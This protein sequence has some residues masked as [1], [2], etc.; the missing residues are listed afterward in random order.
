MTDRQELAASPLW[1][2]V[3][4]RPLPRLHVLSDLHLES[5][6]YEIAP[7]VDFDILVAAGDIGPLDLAVPWLA[8]V[9]KPVVYVLGNHERYGMDILQAVTKAKK[10]AEAT[11]VRVLERDR[12]VINGVRFLGC[13]LWTDL[14]KLHPDFVDAA[15]RMMRDYSH[16]SC[17]EWLTE[18]SNGKRLAGLCK[19]HGFKPPVRD[20][21]DTRT[22]LHPSVTYLEHQASLKWL[23]AQV[24]KPFAGLTV[25]VTHHAPS[26]ESLRRSG[27]SHVALDRTRWG[28]RDPEP[29][30][31][32]AYASDGLLAGFDSKCIDLWVHGHVHTGMDYLEHRIRVVCNPR[33]LHL[34]PITKAEAE[35][36]RFFGYPVS[37]ADIKRSEDVSA[38]NPFCG[39]AAEFDPKLVVD[40]ERGFERPI[41]QACEEP[42]EKMRELAV[43][44]KELLP[45]AG[46]GKSVP[47]QCVTESFEARLKVQHQQ[48]NSVRTTVFAMLDKYW[49]KSSLS[50]IRL[51]PGGRLRSVWRGED[52][53]LGPRDFEQAYEGVLAAI[54]WL[55]CL[56]TVVERN[57]RELRDRAAKAMSLAEEAGLRI[58]MCRLDPVALRAVD[59]NNLQFIAVELTTQND[60][61]KAALNRLERLLDDVLNDG[62][63]PR[64]WPFWVRASGD[65]QCPLLDA[66]Q[67]S[68]HSRQGLK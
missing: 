24:A 31:I 50:N 49:N 21:D 26:Y 53:S 6:P 66:S 8:A 11:Q 57:L 33:G 20:E 23:T 45:F 4:D 17:D 65:V 41:C 56:P 64:E 30:R 5:G 61:S 7:S 48:L 44:L 28:Y 9:G 37:E 51:A 35:G 13:T 22:L 42:L 19:R 27:L 39:D 46:L 25:V 16:I 32:A 34:G 15:H 62:K 55:E 14:R 18:D 47:D 10:L 12:V 2:L 38:E 58:R 68:G 36:F 54:G 59:E 52:E 67:L 3:S 1:P 29:A 60:E 43:E 63:T 40:F